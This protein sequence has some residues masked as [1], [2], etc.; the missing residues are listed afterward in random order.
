V[1]RTFKFGDIQNTSPD[2]NMN[3]AMN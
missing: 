3:I 2:I 1:Q